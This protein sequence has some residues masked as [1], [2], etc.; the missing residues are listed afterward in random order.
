MDSATEAS[1]AWMDQWQRSAPVWLRLWSV[2]P[3]DCSGADRAEVRGAHRGDGGWAAARRVGH[4]AAETV[5][6]GVRKGFCRGQ[7]P[8]GRGGFAGGGPG[9]AG[10]GEEI[11][12]FLGGGGGGG[13]SVG[14]VWGGVGGGRGGR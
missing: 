3:P 6:A 7:K 10:G 2:D 5:A 8:G 12:F 1:G 13:G 11:F 4:H 9:P 14:G